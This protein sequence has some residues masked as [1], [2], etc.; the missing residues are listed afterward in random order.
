MNR[1]RVLG[2]F[3]TIGFV[4]CTTA[5]S[6]RINFESVALPKMLALSILA[7][8]IL[9]LL[10]LQLV[11]G[12]TFFN[13]LLAGVS[14]I[15]FVNLLFIFF[16]SGSNYSQQFFGVF[17]RNHGLLAQVSFL[18]IFLFIANLHFKEIIKL[19]FFF[20]ASY[21]SLI[22]SL[23]FGLVQ[24]FTP[25]ND[26]LISGTSDITSFF[27]NSNF[28]SAILGILV[29]FPLVN[30]RNFTNRGLLSLNLSLIFLSIFLIFKIGDLQGVFLFSISLI[31]L[32]AI[33]IHRRNVYVF[34]GYLGAVLI[35]GLLVVISTFGRG[36]LGN[37]LVQ[38]SNL[39][40]SDYYRSAFFVGKS[41]ILTGA[42]FESFLDTYTQG[43]D[44]EAYNR[45]NNVLVDSPHNFL[46]NQFVDGGLPL[47][48]L[49]II[50]LLAVLV[51]VY[52][53]ISLLSSLDNL[54]LSIILAWLCS[55]A[56]LMV[57]P[58]TISILLWFWILSGAILSSNFIE[59]GVG[60]NEL[61][62]RKKS[63]FPYSSLKV[64]TLKLTLSI[65]VGSGIG[66]TSV[67]P[68]FSADM[69]LKRGLDLGSQKLLRLAAED[70]PYQ[71]TRVVLVSNVFFDN[72][73][74]PEGI[75]VLKKAIRDNPDCLTCWRLLLKYEKDEQFRL[76]AL[77]QLYRLD[78]QSVT[79][80]K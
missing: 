27:G 53:S 52:R 49:T 31:F 71:Q 24:V 38:Q 75:A 34:A 12:R 46:L 2:L 79:I 67:L 68:E 22:L 74:V 57:S 23:I 20:N 45:R 78:P 66:I 70:S 42:G 5:Y 80:R 50:F 63:N 56:S 77:K 32:L 48:V 10:I 43:R 33:R 19:N 29:V 17:G 6:T 4:F 73:L 14:L 13:K 7:F 44:S 25:N 30:C 61:F 62:D 59:G 9:L 65:L 76:T 35:V 1:T 28:F 47:L 64:S 37:L 8:S 26:N 69:Q 51:R 18:V 58:S 16:F 60:D 41:N 55:F 72:S 39:F 11:E 21:I 54:R 3:L 15:Y 36:P 40:R